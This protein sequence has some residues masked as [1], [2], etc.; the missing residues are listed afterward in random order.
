MIVDPAWN[1]DAMLDR[2]EADGIKVVG[3]LAT[4]YHQDHIGGEVFGL[5]IEGVA[6]L[7]SRNPVPIHVNEV[8]A[9]GLRA[10]AFDLSDAPDLLPPL[11]ALAALGAGGVAL[12]L[13]T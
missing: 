13:A 5:K 9:D 8:E 1:V 4:H 6:Q 2:A 3:A 10:F 12:F 11:A 7:L